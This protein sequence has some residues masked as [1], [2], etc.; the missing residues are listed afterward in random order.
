MLAREMRSRGTDVMY[1]LRNQRLKGSANLE[2]RVGDFDL[3]NH[4]QHF[5]FNSKHSDGVWILTFNQP[6]FGGT[7]KAATT[8][9]CL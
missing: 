4:F 7:A 5:S 8:P 2:I 9:D 3:N 1:A 6:W